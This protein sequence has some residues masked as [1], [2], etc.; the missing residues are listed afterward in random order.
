MYGPVQSSNQ[1]ELEA[2]HGGADMDSAAPRPN[3]ALLVGVGTAAAQRARL[4]A[5]VQI[6]EADKVA[7]LAA[8]RYEH[9]VT[10]RDVLVPL[11]AAAAAAVAE[12]PPLGEGALIAA[13]GGTGEPASGASSLHPSLRCS[14]WRADNRYFSADVDLLALPLEQP[15]AW[16]AVC[17]VV[18]GEQGPAGA[19]K[20]RCQALVAVVD[21]G[22]SPDAL[23]ALAAAAEE[24]EPELL[25]LCELGETPAAEPA[26]EP[27]AAAT[28]AREDRLAHMDGGGGG[29]DEGPLWEW[30]VANGFEHVVLPWHVAVGAPA[31][32]LAAAG[33][34]TAE[35]GSE[36]GLGRVAEALQN[37]M[38]SVSAHATPTTA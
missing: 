13:L 20:R 25:L 28:G 7:A 9:C 8:E 37:T 29:E 24:A 6:L 3:S 12:L 14:A 21:A 17:A 1:L 36:Q 18:L 16:P 4:D 2:E 27:A 31:D 33:S 32:L 34:S 10:L 15:P 35:P 19:S 26:A 38:W 11:K 5:A 22:T 23:A 30:S